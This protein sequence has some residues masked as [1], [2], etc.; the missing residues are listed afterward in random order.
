MILAAVLMLAGFVLRCW[1]SNF[2]SKTY[3]FQ[4]W[5]TPRIM[6]SA[7]GLFAL[8]AGSLIA[9][10]SGAVLFLAS[11]DFSFWARLIIFLAGSW[12]FYWEIPL[13]LFQDP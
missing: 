1:T 5:R 4:R 11:V 13:V 2:S 8:M 3:G 6:W 12:F 9:W 10:I 7:S